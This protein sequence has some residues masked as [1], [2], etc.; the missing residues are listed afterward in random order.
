VAH[1]HGELKLSS[2]EIWDL[3]ISDNE[4]ILFMSHKPTGRYVGIP[5]D[6]QV[7][8]FEYETNPADRQTFGVF[9]ETL[10]IPP[11]VK[12]EPISTSHPEPAPW[13]EKMEI[14]QYK[15][16]DSLLD[17]KKNKVPAK[18]AVVNTFAPAGRRSG[19]ATEMK[20]AVKK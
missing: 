7:R 3:Q 11:N 15:D 12:V 17:V 1:T 8:Y 4:R 6:G 9:P 14:P 18:E 5:I 20:K 19:K 16:S 2:G 10:P 13:F